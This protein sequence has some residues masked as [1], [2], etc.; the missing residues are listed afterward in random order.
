MTLCLIRGAQSDTLNLYYLLPGLLNENLTTMRKKCRINLCN[1]QVSVAWFIGDHLLLRD[2]GPYGII[3][4][5]MCVVIIVDMEMLL[6]FLGL[7]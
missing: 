2:F 3:Y 5:T 1:K 6:S 7:M 4:M